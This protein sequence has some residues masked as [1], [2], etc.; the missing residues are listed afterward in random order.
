V[1]A[2]ILGQTLV[3]QPIKFGWSP[4]RGPYTQRSWKGT[5]TQ[6]KSK[7]NE[8][9]SLGG[10]Y[11]V[12]QL[13]G[14]FWMIT[15]SYGNNTG[16]GD[17]SGN[18]VTDQWELVPNVVSQ[19]LLESQY[20]KVA[21]L[22][23]TQV[24][25]IKDSLAQNVEPSASGFASDQLT[26]YTLMHSNV[27]TVSVSQPVLQHNWLVPIGVNLAYSYSNIDRIFTTASLISTEG[28]P[29]DLAVSISAWTASFAN[30]SYGSNRV[31]LVFGWKKLA[32]TQRIANNG[33]RE[34]TQGFEFGLWS[35]DI[36]GATV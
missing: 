28:V 16:G 9:I 4:D 21:G 6:V 5:E 26:V 32:P 15:A 2:I 7:I 14:E 1:S 36:Y 8:I 33:R 22:S 24:K 29:A 27:D 20:S 30:P 25:Q 17:Q 23:T 19:N 18:E 31:A 12:E 34:I 13:A 10:S 35:T 3:E 11:E